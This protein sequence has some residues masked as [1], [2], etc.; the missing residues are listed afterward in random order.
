MT[1]VPFSFDGYS[2]LTLSPQSRWQDRLRRFNSTV[3]AVA[4]WFYENKLLREHPCATANLMMDSVVDGYQ[5]WALEVRS[6]PSNAWQSLCM[7]MWL[8][9]RDRAF[10]ED[11]R[12]KSTIDALTVRQAG[13]R[14]W[15]EF[16]RTSSD[17]WEFV[18]LF[19]HFEPAC[20]EGWP[21]PGDV[22]YRK[23]VLLSSTYFERMRRNGHL[24]DC[25]GDQRRAP[26][27]GRPATHEILELAHTKAALAFRAEAQLLGLPVDAVQY[28]A[29][30]PDGGVEAIEGLKYFFDLW[31]EEDSPDLD[32]E[33]MAE[34]FVCFGLRKLLQSSPMH[35]GRSQEE[36]VL[37]YHK[38]IRHFAH[39]MVVCGAVTPFGQAFSHWLP[40]II[41]SP[42]SRREL[43]AN[44]AELERFFV[45][46]W[47]GDDF[48][49]A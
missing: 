10:S 42:A 21:V 45:R 8:S 18:R 37:E 40:E 34:S 24:N 19:R 35:L 7:Y 30:D 11:D 15:A 32:S 27:D 38:A 39:A 29:W 1:P 16:A 5:A 14:L 43:D 26:V 31:V 33:Q 48:V 46:D 9:S 23:C 17:Q 6:Y 4:V 44:L 20:L 49:E 41:D 28:C 3:P 36:A 2:G 47:F 25:Q 13:L 12:H 22:G